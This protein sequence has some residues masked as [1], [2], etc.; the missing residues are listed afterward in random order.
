MEVTLLARPKLEIFSQKITQK[1]MV[2]T[3]STIRTMTTQLIA[4]AIT[5]ITITG[6]VTLIIHTCRTLPIKHLNKIQKMQKLQAKETVL[7]T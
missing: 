1:M 6:R 3:T 4:I 7:R 5:T 2:F